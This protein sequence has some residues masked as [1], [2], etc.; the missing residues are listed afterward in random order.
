M[1][2]ERSSSLARVLSIGMYVPLLLL[3]DYIVT[4]AEPQPHYYTN[5]FNT[6]SD[7]PSN[8]CKPMGYNTAAFLGTN[9]YPQASITLFQTSE[10]FCPV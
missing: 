3:V 10:I 2:E 7:G 9:G 6:G 1:R 8:K 5:Q 4:I